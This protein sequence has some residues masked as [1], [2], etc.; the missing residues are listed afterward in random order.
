MRSEQYLLGLDA[1]LSVTK[2]ALF[3]ASGREV[4]TVGRRS[5][6][7]S[8][9]PGW[10]EL[11]MLD[12]WEST[13]EAI[14]ELLVLS[15]VDKTQI[16]GVGLSGNMVGAWLIDKQGHP[17]RNA[18]LVCDNRTGPLVEQ[19]IQEQ[20]DILH[21]I[22]CS[23]GCVMEFG[24]TLPL[25]RWLDEHEAD[26]LRNAHT[27]LCSK[28][29]ICYQFTGSRQLDYT[30]AAVLPGDN[31]ARA[32]NESLF[33]L[34]GISRW[35][36]LFP[37]VRASY[38]LVGRITSQAAEQSGLS[39]G[40]PVVAGAGDVPSSAIGAGAVM[41]GMA[42]T[43]LGT[44]CHNSLVVSQAV[45]E[46]PDVG[47]LFVLPESFWLRTMVNLTGTP[48]L[49]WGIKQFCAW[50][51]EVNLSQQGIF[52]T[53]QTLAQQSPPG[54]NGVIFHPYLHPVGV[55]APF[56]EPHAKAQFFGITNSTTRHD[57][58]RAIYEGVALAIRD[59]YEAIG[60][61]DEIR[62]VGGGT[63]S[64]FWCR[65]IADCTGSRI[66]IPDGNEFG[67]KGAAL[68]AAVGLGWFEDISEASQKTSTIR[69]RYAPN[70]DLKA[71]Y[72]AAYAVYRQLRID[73][74]ASWRLDNTFA[75][76][77]G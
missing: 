4:L 18:I 5:R 7:L 63:K 51:R 24:C 17:V 11:D 47:L 60:V 38:Q 16:S 9:Q 73:L 66:A 26:S 46:P 53:A 50:E 32:Y 12:M 10:A 65:V 15:Q 76:D 61:P 14:R 13:V 25:I 36:H 62:L 33:D 44:T 74:R 58:L 52:E 6:L 75:V 34:L 55:I 30:E 71:V 23:S 77:R 19:L 31:Q 68:L 28:D 72:D 29:W 37:P 69:R 49:D 48:N 3:D 22:Y 67:A 42:C 40:T 8:P 64:D 56:V 2:A 45:F 43:V 41:P 21:Q 57:L 59:C 20:P 35:R 27:V 39:V 70:S 54:A 1:G